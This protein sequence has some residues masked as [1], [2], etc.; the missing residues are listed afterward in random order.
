MKYQA[1]E[2]GTAFSMEMRMPTENVYEIL[3]PG[4][5]MEMRMP[6][7]NLYEILATGFGME[8]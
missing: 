7:E 2:L 3:A 1:L 8:I 6:I 4:F 5:C